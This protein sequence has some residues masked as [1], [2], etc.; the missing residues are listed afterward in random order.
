MAEEFRAS[1]TLVM[2]PSE[3]D[4]SLR[5]YYEQTKLH[6][7]FPQFSLRAAGSN[8]TAAEGRLQT[9]AG[10]SY[11]IRVE[12]PTGYPFSMPSVR[13]LGWSPE[14]GT[15]HVYNSNT[16]CVM[17]ESQWRPTFTIAFMVAKAAIWVNK[18]EVW[19]TDRVWPGAQQSHW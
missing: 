17:R 1:P 15:G 2:M 18:Y 4:P 16:L 9:N 3:S 7:A 13:P 5:M 12:L 11:G 6:S 8:I 14:S 19:R 10:R